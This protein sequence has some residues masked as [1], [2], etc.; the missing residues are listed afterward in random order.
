[1]S[2]RRHHRKV[3]SY[4]FFCFQ[5]LMVFLAR[6]KGSIIYFILL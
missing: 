6:C 3:K 1:L 2:R 5:D 4:I